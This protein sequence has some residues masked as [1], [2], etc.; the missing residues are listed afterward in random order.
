MAST[1]KR[2]LVFAEPGADYR[3]LCDRL[4]ETFARAAAPVEVV[5][6]TSAQMR[7]PGMMDGKNTIGF[8][9]PG[10]S[11]AN[12]DHKL[13]PD[14]IE[15]LR[16][17]VENGGRFMGIC[18]GAY[19]ACESIEWFKWE[20]ARFKTKTPRI[21]FFNYR[22]HG[23]IRAL[24]DGQTDLGSALSHTAVAEIEFEENGRKQS[25]RIM[26]WGGP[27]LSGESEGHVI[28]RFNGLAGNPPA[29]V[30]RNIGKGR[31]IISAVHPE[32]RGEDF[33]MAIYGQDPVHERARHIAH[34]VANDEGKRDR[35]WRGLMRRLFPEYI[36]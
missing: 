32:I 33:A 23:P 12:Y 11:D 9:L 8:F 34:A 15:R 1:L 30:A 31:A 10:A 7:I 36:R 28:A 13:G 27:E 24:L 26:Y 29:I 4:R 2:V 19:Y 3:T 6:V 20:P 18:A 25:A 16:R 21:D 17:F 14:N 35:L 5:P 22:A